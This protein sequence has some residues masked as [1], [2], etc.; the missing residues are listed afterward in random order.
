MNLLIFLLAITEP[1]AQL[2]VKHEGEKQRTF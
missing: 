1:G 2:E